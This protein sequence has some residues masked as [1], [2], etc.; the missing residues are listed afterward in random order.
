M[1]PAKNILEET[2]WKG[3]SKPRWVKLLSANNVQHDNILTCWNKTMYANSKIII[4]YKW[5]S[6][7][8]ELFLAFERMKKFETS[9]MDIVKCILKWFHDCRRK[10]HHDLWVLVFQRLILRHLILSLL[11]IKIKDF[12][13]PLNTHLTMIRNIPGQA[14]AIEDKRVRIVGRQ[15]PQH[16]SWRP[17]QKVGGRKRG[18]YRTWKN[19]V[20][21]RMWYFIFKK[22]ELVEQM[23]ST[24]IRLI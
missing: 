22:L 12:L 19:E 14:V 23:T 24:Q 21:L 16:V 1:H 13:Y 18:R 5:V 11:V 3:N 15:Q 9:L 20:N 2:V 17:E 6:C 8:S 10:N 7:K 4:V